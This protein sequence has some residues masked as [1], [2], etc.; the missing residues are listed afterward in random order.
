MLVDYFDWA[1]WAMLCIGTS[2]TIPYS[3]NTDSQASVASRGLCCSGLW[4]VV[5][6]KKQLPINYKVRPLCH[7][8]I[9]QF[10]CNNCNRY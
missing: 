3:M 8:K 6:V 4:T 9:P 7:S 2:D 1:V 10:M 5:S